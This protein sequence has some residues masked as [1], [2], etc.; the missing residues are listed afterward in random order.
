MN[1]DTLKAW[2]DEYL[3]ESN[4]IWELMKT[5]RDP[6]TSNLFE[7][8]QKKGLR[9]LDEVGPQVSD[10]VSRTQFLEKDF[11]PF[12]LRLHDPLVPGYNNPKSDG[13]LAVDLWGSLDRIRS[14]QI[15]I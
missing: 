12:A 2:R 15:T 4:E 7:A 9:F 3:K 5:K 11:I 8:L 13:L 1:V 10:K 14:R 6:T